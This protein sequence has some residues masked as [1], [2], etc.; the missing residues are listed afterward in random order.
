MGRLLLHVRGGSGVRLLRIPNRNRLFL[1]DGVIREET[2]LPSFY[3][4]WTATVGILFVKAVFP[5]V[6]KMFVAEF[7]VVAFVAVAWRV[8]LYRSSS[9]RSQTWTEKTA[10]RGEGNEGLPATIRR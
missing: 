3:M 10:R 4:T 5:S 9:N 2:N 7:I 6:V 8:L 1:G